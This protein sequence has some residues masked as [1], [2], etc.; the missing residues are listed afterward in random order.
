MRIHLT[1]VTSFD[2]RLSRFEILE[3]VTK[4]PIIIIALNIDVIILFFDN[5]IRFLVIINQTITS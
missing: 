4:S 1:R 2:V 5:F 3:I